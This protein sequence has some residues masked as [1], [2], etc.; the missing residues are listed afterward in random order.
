MEKPKLRDE[1]IIKNK[2]SY[3]WGATKGSY[4]YGT[5]YHHNC[6]DNLNYSGKTSF[7]LPVLTS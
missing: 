4:G 3:Y 1:Y 6:N 7:S 5:S 2:T